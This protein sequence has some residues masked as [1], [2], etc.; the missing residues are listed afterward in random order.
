MAVVINH[1]VVHCYNK[2]ESAAFIADVLGLP[3]PRPFHCFQVVC[4]D[5]GATLDFLDSPDNE[6]VWEHFAFL[7][8]EGDFDAIFA[9][10]QTR[11]MQFWSDPFCK[12]PGV[13]NTDDGGRSIYFKDPNGH[14]LEILTVPYGGERLAAKYIA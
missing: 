1:I 12:L 4:L 6:I 11:K 10:I 3:E 2:E 5:N 14:L 13:I 8:D 7:V 9:R